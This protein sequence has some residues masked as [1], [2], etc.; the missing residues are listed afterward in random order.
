MDW[1]SL[2]ASM[3]IYKDRDFP[4]RTFRNRCLTAVLE[5]H[6]Y[7]HIS[8]PFSQELGGSGEYIPLSN[9]RPSVTSGLCRTVVDDA[10]SLL[11]SE[12]HFPTVRCS[13]AATVEALTALIKERR[14]NELLCDAATRG[15]VGSVAIL[16]R[17]LKAKP[18]FSVMQTAYLTPAWDPLD[19]DTLLS[20]TERYKVP[21]AD[22]LA[23]GYRVNIDD[24]M[25]WFM[26]RWDAEAETWFL[27][28]PVSKTDMV[29]VAD[30]DRTVRHGLGFV[31]LVWVKNLPGGDDIDGGCTFETGISTNIEID[32]SLSQAGRSLKYAGDPKLVIRDVT[33]DDKRPMGGAANALVLSDPQSD[34]KFLEINGSASAAVRGYVEYLRGMALEAMHGMRADTSKMAAATSGRALEI[35]HQGLIWLADKL[36]T[37]YGEG[38]LLSLLRMVCKASE[39][40]PGGLIIGGKARKD[41]VAEELTLVWPRWF[42]PTADDR[43]SDAITAKTLVDAGVLSRETALRNIAS[44]YDVEDVKVEAVIIAA[45]TAAADKRAMD[46]TAQVKASESLPS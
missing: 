4:E 44:D 3:S 35:L 5:G 30:L 23:Q 17:V 27:P 1:L 43:Q 6:Q 13:D 21:A 19:P 26:R 9:R 41:M 46:M 22:L 42:S 14:L 18:F 29:P 36:R 32:Y 33:G 40:V 25:H 11:F 16:F 10:V 34:A 15:S 7:D 31:P 2:Q 38:G 8:T 24:G 12:G 20:V 45:E 37:S 39:Q 28:W